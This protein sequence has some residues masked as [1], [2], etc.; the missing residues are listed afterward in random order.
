MRDIGMIII[1]CSATPIGRAVTVGEIDKWHRERGFACIG[2]HYVIGLDGKVEKG[3]DENQIGA[4][5]EG[6]NSNSIGICYVGGT[7]TKGKPM[8]TRTPEQ[9]VSLHRLVKDLKVK[10]PKVT[11]HGHNEFTKKACPCFDVRK[12]F[13]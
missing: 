6:F 8:D 5:C 1:H 2:Y 3:R 9:I 10:Y 13:K 11:I 7:D 12:E 4:H